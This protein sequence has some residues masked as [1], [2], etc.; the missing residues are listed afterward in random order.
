MIKIYFDCPG[1]AGQQRTFR[2]TSELFDWLIT[3][4]LEKDQVTIHTIQ[5]GGSSG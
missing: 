4:V 1:E 5:I 2:S 3:V